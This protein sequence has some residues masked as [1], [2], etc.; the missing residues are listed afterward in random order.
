V[1]TTPNGTVTGQSVI[2]TNASSANAG[3]YT[4]AVTTYGCSAVEQTIEVKVEKPAKPTTIKEIYYCTGDNA[5]KLTATSLPGYKLVWFDESQTRLTDT[6]T[7]NTSVAGTS[8]YYV[9]Q[10]SIS[11]ANCSSDKEKVTVIIENKPDPV[12]LDPVYICSTLSN[13]QSV[14]VSIPNS[15]AGCIYSLYSQETGGSSAGY[16]ASTGDNLP[17]NITLDNSE[18]NSNKIYYLEVTNKA[19]CVSHR[20]PVEII[21]VEITLSPNELPP[22]QV[23]EFYSQKLVTNAL[24]P[25]YTIV[26]GYLPTGFTLSSNGDISGIA[27]SYEDP[28]VFTVEVVNNLGCSIQKKYTLKSELLVSKMFSPNGDGINDMFMRGY[29]VI[30]FDRLGRKVFSGEDGW[31]GTF[32]GKVMPEDVYYYILYYKDKEG[33]EHHVTNYVTLIKTI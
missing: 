6:P 20:T 5:T 24:A 30:I 15:S 31:D 33:K 28:S 18:I 14:S 19:G 11:D 26:E 12:I 16:A 32:N 3:I 23:D 8:I 13:A 10:V 4:L 22:Y 9:S 17:V 29:K 2:I 7:P 21:L 27:S 1:W 25:Q